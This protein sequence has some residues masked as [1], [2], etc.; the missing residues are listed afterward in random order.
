MM[1]PMTKTQVYFADEDLDALHKVAKKTKKPVAQ[2]VR[3][4]VREVWLRPKADGPV[5]LWT[6]PSRRSSAEH[7]SIY[8]EL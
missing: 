8:D 6:G 5:A 7:D 2:L 3:E 1:T 4:A